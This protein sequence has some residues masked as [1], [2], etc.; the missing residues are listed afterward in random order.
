MYNVILAFPERFDGNHEYNVGDDYPRKGFKPPAGR[1]DELLNGTN[2]AGMVYLEAIEPV[3]D[4]AP[5]ETPEDKPKGK[6]KK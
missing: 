2:R 3:A 5:D 6:G 1:V 4:K